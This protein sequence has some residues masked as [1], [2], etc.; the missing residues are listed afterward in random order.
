MTV[1][2]A[3]SL[4]NLG[5]AVRRL[6]SETGG[7]S[8]DVAGLPLAPDT[9]SL[10]DIDLMTGRSQVGTEWTRVEFP[11]PFDAVPQVAVQADGHAAEV[12]NVGVAGFEA[13][14]IA[15]SALNVTTKKV[16][17]F[18]TK[19]ATAKTEVTVVTGVSQ[20]TSAQSGQVTLMWVAI[21]SDGE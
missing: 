15:N 18:A 6:R 8:S 12:R 17:A 7:A 16:W 14:V 13:R 9:W 1:E 19:D 20:T 3:V 5:R 2:K 4:T 10:E 21:E 11:R